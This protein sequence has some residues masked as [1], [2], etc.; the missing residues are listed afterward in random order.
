MASL[1]GTNWNQEIHLSGFINFF[2]ILIILMRCKSVSKRR[3][4]ETVID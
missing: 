4:F 2:A 1:A 3:G